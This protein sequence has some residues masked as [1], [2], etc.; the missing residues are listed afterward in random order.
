M[1]AGEKVAV[2]PVGKPVAVKLT[3]P[4]YAP[5]VGAS[6]KL[7]VAVPPAAMLWLEVPV[8]P[9]EKSETGAWPTV[10]LAVAVADAK[11]AV[12]A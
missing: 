3:A 12:A 8:V 10:K 2:A 9:T 5:P 1:L 7:N 6:E 11:F 4:G